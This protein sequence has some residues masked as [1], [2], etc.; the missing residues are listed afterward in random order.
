MPDTPEPENGEGGE[1]EARG[2]IVKAQWSAPLPPPA[3]LAEFE[4]ILPGAAERIFAQFES[5][6]SHRRLLEREDARFASR[7]AAVGQALAGLYALAA[8]SL[9]GFAIYMSAT[10]VA[11]FLGGGTIVS[12]VIAFLRRAK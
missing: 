7:D 9:T 10:W 6:A 12:G 4:R 1:E 2:E 3:H 8:F 5:E 11:A